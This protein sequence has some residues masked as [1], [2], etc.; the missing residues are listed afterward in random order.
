MSLRQPPKRLLYSIATAV[1]VAV[2]FFQFLTSS[3]Q[4]AWAS[5]GGGRRMVDIQN[6]TLGV[7]CILLS[8]HVYLQLCCYVSRSQYFLLVPVPSL[9]SVYLV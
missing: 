4:Q 3:A 2:L 9:N 8:Y 6:T 1:T 5:S 7:S